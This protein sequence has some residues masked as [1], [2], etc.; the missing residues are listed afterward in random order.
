MAADDS[1]DSDDRGDAELPDQVDAEQARVLIAGGRVRVIDIRSEDDFAE[2]RMSNAI[3]SDPDE[4]DSAIEDRETGR[5]AVLVVCADGSE[6]ADVAE[7]LRSDGVDAT[8]IDGGFD[9]WRSDGLPTAPGADEEYEGPPIKIPGAVDSSGD[10]EDE[11]DETSESDESTESEV[12]SE[13]D[14]A[15]PRE[16]ETADEESA[17]RAEEA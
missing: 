3:R 11:D 15:E 9:S 4:I 14:R 10:D 2:E 5:D 7:K 16:E 1:S 6:S 17:E 12:D 8:S 13:G